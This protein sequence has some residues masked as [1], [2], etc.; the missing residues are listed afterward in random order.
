MSA[1][2]S[3]TEGSGVSDTWALVDKEG[4]MEVSKSNVSMLALP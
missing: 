1:H 4:E 3:D 2:G